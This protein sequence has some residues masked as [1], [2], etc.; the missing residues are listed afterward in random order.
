[1]SQC[2]GIRGATTADAN[3]RNAITHA[4]EELLR[5]LVKANELAETDVSA[6]F[7]TTTPDLNAEFPAMAA[8]IGLGWEHTALMS[9]HEIDVPGAPSSVIRVLVLANTEKDKES[10]VHVYLKGAQHLRARG[11][12]KQ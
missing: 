11:T 5:E 1:M 3:T 9:S 6:V 7:F 12:S 10:L 2:L 4:T 8:R